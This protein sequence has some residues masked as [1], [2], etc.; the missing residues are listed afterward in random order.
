M[1]TMLS[2]PVS[3]L[4]KDGV[5]GSY[6]YLKEGILWVNGKGSLGSRFSCDGLDQGSANVPCKEPTSQ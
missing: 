6:R 5:G 2:L 4:R 1:E 3:W